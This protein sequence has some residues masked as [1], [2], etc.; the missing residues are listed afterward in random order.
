MMGRNDSALLRFSVHELESLRLNDDILSFNDGIDSHMSWLGKVVG[1][2]FGFLLGGPLGAI[3]GASVGH[4]FDAGMEGLDLDEDLSPGAQH[5][6]Q[7]A[8][9]PRLFR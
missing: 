9:L 6:V 5:R 4:Q 3:L 2:A 1:G 7:M 8:F